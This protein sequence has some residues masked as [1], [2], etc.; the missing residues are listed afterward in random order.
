MLDQV[1]ST[2]F[3]NLF[4]SAVILF[5][6]LR[7]S[8]NLSLRLFW[9]RSR[10]VSL[11][12]CPSGQSLL[13]IFLSQKINTERDL[14]SQLPTCYCHDLISHSDLISLSFTENFIQQLISAVIYRGQMA[15]HNLV[16]K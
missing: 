2:N 8:I 16:K 15:T 11:I 12:E 9:V 13:M 10:C 14:D 1:N 5:L 6:H 3:T 4:C 7:G